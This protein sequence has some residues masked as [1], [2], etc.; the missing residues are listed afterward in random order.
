M[1]MPSTDGERKAGSSIRL[2]AFCLLR[3]G[4]ARD[5]G[6][7]RALTLFRKYFALKGDAMSPEERREVGSL[8]AENKR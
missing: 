6:K 5:G 3:R 1:N 8:I 7:D 4:R 2:L